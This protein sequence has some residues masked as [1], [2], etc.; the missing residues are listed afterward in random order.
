MIK[1]ET[2]KMRKA[3]NLRKGGSK[4]SVAITEKYTLI[5]NTNCPAFSDDIQFIG[6]NI[7]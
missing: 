4:K 3:F 5:F 2:L 6:S 1:R 7:E